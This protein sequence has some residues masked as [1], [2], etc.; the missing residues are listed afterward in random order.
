MIRLSLYYLREAQRKLFFLIVGLLVIGGMAFV[1][2]D[3]G[4]TI[5]YIA[6][7]PVFIFGETA[8]EHYNNTLFEKLLPLKQLQII[9][10]KYAVF[11]IVVLLSFL[12]LSLY[13]LLAMVR[14][15]FEFD[16][17][18]H[19]IFFSHILSIG[20]NWGVFIILLSC[21]NRKPL[22]FLT[23]SLITCVCT[24]FPLQDFFQTSSLTDD[25]LM[26]VRFIVDYF[27]TKP[28]VFELLLSSLFLIGSIPLAT[29]LQLNKQG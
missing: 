17:I 27:W 26:I 19:L 10:S 22:L 9:A 29:Y 21:S 11:I 4:I 25:F 16:F 20:L 7:L 1:Q 28:A 18:A 3:H 23:L 2:R 12:G 13:L 14:E 6:L 8:S 24:F 5:V 15:G